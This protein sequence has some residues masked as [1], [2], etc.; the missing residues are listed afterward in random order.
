MEILIISIILGLANAALG[1]IAMW[2]VYSKAGQ[3]GWA[4]IVPFYNVIVSLRIVSKPWW[5]IF[6]ILIPGINVIFVII[7]AHRFSK[8][9]GQGVGFTIGL[10]LLYYIF[11]LL[12]G[13]G[14][15]EYRK[16]NK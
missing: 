9:F 15:Y 3:P 6:L 14:D 10:I 16:L 1:V 13:F 11:I 2:R 5:W 4:S 8:C 7:I 12:L